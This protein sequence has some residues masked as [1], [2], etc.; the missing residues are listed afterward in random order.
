MAFHQSGSD[1]FYGVHIC[2]V[3]RNRW[4]QFQHHEGA[5]L[6]TLSIAYYMQDTHT[7]PIIF[8]STVGA[9]E[10]D[11]RCIFLSGLRSKDRG[12]Q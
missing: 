8:G 7:H 4:Q 2:D 10:A 9:V 11:E 1:V 12:T 6:V 5:V 3:N